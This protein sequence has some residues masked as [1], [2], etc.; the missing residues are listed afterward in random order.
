MD[1]ILNAVALNGILDIDEFLFEARSAR[2]ETPQFE[3]AFMDVA[4]AIRKGCQGKLRGPV[5]VL[6]H[7]LHRLTSA[8]GILP[9]VWIE[10]QGLGL[11]GDFRGDAAAGKPGITC[12]D[13]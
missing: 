9:E 2:P 10:I 6:Y 4:A 1:L 5:T 3:L 8:N 11:Q 13:I 7:G 12:Q